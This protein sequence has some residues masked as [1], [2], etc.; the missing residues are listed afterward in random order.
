MSLALGMQNGAFQSTGGI[1]VHTTY[2][3]GMITG[4]VTAEARKSNLTAR[5]PTQGFLCTIWAAFVLGGTAGA[6]FALHFGSAGILGAAF[7]LLVIIV[8]RVRPRSTRFVIRPIADGVSFVG[9]SSP[10]NSSS[11]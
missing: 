10:S 6:A 9:R 11:S 7:L 2:L 8:C 4:L 1:S 5:D 3:T